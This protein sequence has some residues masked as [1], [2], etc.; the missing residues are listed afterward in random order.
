MPLSATVMPIEP[1]RRR[2]LEISTRVAC[3]CWRTFARSS[4]I[5]SY[6]TSLT[7]VSKR[8]WLASRLTPQP[9]CPEARKVSQSDSSFEWSS[10]RLPLCIREFAK[11]ATE[12]ASEGVEVL[13]RRDR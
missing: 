12:L 7:S 2:T 9:I 11:N 4:R 13:H 8:V 6:T 1:S 3:A 5:V 10:V